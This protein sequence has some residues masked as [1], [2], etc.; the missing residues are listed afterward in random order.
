MVVSGRNS[1][2]NSAS[3]RTENNPPQASASGFAGMPDPPN[4]DYDLDSNQGDIDT[5][6]YRFTQGHLLGSILLKLAN[7]NTALARKCHLRE[8]ET[9]IQDLCA[10]FQAALQIEKD[11]VIN[12][13][14]RV[15]ADEREKQ[16]Q[17]ELNNHTLN[18]EIEPPAYFSPSATW[19]TPNRMADSMKIFPSRTK[20]SGSQKDNYMTIVEFLSLVNT[21]QRQCR[22]SEDEFKDALKA[23][24][25]GKAHI[26]LAEWIDNGL[27]MSS[28][29]H[30][31]TLHFD[32]R[33]T[34]EEARALINVYRAPK[35][36]NLAEVIS[37]LMML[38]SRISASMHDEISRKSTYNNEVI[39]AL[40]RCLPS[41]SATLVRNIFNQLSARLGRSCDATEL[42][43]ALNIYRSTI[44]ADIKSSGADLNRGRQSN[45]TS[46]RKNKNPNWTQFSSYNLSSVAS[47]MAN[48]IFP[49]RNP[50]HKLP[51]TRP[52]HAQNRRPPPPR[53]G[54]LKLTNNNMSANRNRRIGPSRPQH[55]KK[56]RHVPTGCTLC[57]KSDHRA[58]QGCP[59]MRTDNGQIYKVMPA[60]S[61][62]SACPGN[63]KNTL[64]HPPALCPFRKG[65]PL[66]RQG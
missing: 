21:A 56:I 13:C 53:Q 44:D 15:S 1:L 36:S 37:H 33:L 27:D 16:L 26:L 41:T 5:D 51:A 48:K 54:A 6:E 64:N 35:N 9:N 65:G 3:S 12:S 55:N 14:L 29:Y 39:N 66:E 62:C 25:T 31:F 43:R 34:A 30:N 10:D 7:D 63:K 20:F 46:H 38:G 42:S 47:N 52:P 32:K 2:S 11:A 49:S 45:N 18:Q 23:C 60:H 19:T 61:T 50:Y 59:N 24:T 22:L 40:M 17:Q 58:S 57:G 8:M 4:N 28:I